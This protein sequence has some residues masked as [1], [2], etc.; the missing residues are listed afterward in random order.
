MKRV[1]KDMDIIEIY[2]IVCVCVYILHGGCM[3]MCDESISHESGKLRRKGREECEC[4]WVRCLGFGTLAKNCKVYHFW[5]VM[6]K[7]GN[8][9]F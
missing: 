9:E 2:N 4:M 8:T 6:E 3:Y 7:L 1:S 5:N